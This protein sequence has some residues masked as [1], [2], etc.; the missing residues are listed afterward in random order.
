MKLTVYCSF[1][2]A[3]LFK[4]LFRYLSFFHFHKPG[5]HDDAPVVPLS[6]LNKVR[7]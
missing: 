3:L 7:T 5:D 6:K 4:F 1:C 2:I